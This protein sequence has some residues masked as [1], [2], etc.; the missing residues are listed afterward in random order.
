MSRRRNNP[1]HAKKVCSIIVEG[2]TE[3]WYLQLFKK[4]ENI[5]GMDIK[6]ELPD[7]N[8]F[9]EKYE[10]VKEHALIYDKVLWIID[11]DVLIKEHEEQKHQRR[12]KLDDL[13]TYIS[14]ILNEYDNVQILV[15]TPCLEFWFLLHLKNCGKYYRQCKNVL[16]QFRYTILEDYKKTEKYYKQAQNDIYI[17]LNPMRNEAISR[18]I[19]LGDFDLLN[20]EQAKA[21]IYKIFDLI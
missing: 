7:K 4:H 6:P 17:K 1:K 2:K 9:S 21:E 8:N 5:Q 20:A 19:V 18:A 13:K 14:E 11:L 15:N 3:L 10:L 12:S 16:K